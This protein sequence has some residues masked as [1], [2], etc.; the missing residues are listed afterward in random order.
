MLKLPFILD[1]VVI[2]FMGSIKP[3]YTK[4]GLK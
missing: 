3:W 1:I 4:K 2:F